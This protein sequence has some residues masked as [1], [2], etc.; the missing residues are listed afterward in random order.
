MNEKEKKERQERGRERRKKRERRRG[1]RDDR[2]RGRSIFSIQ[3]KDDFE[4][5]EIII[6]KRTIVIR[7]DE[8]MA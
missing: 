7:T 1:G 8:R 3:K 5:V 4:Y 2:G 6:R